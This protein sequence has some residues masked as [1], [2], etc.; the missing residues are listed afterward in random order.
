MPIDTCGDCRFCH[1]LDLRSKGSPYWCFA[2]MPYQADIGVPDGLL[3]RG[4]E[5]KTNLPACRY[6]IPKKG[7][8]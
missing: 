8:H 4:A 1:A 6:F 3:N 5:T 2:D 7:A